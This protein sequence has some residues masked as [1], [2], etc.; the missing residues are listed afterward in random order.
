[1]NDYDPEEE[2]CKEIV[3]HY[4][5]DEGKIFYYN[6]DNFQTLDSDGDEID[7]WECSCG[8]IVFANAIP[9]TATGKIQELIERYSK[10]KSFT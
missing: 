9:S 1:M 4:H 3:D 8:H 2:F 6:S 7:H 5:G 10:L